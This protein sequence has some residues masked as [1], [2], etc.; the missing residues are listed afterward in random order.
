MIY[1]RLIDGKATVAVM[2]RLSGQPDFS[3]NFVI[4]C[5]QILS[6]ILNLTE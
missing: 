6:S 4:K 3:I 2:F 1:G 5:H